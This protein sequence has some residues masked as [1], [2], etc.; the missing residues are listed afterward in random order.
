[1]AEDQSSDDAKLKLL[2]QRVRE[3]WAKLHAPTAEH[4][5]AVRVIVREQTEREQ[6]VAKKS[7]Q[8]NG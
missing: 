2:G 4:L 5:Q 6:A 8:K 1:M 3:G 7:L